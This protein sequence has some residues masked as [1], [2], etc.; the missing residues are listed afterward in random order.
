LRCVLGA[1]FVGLGLA[2]RYGLQFRKLITYMR[3]KYLPKAPAS[4]RAAVVRLE[5]V[6][7]AF[8]RGDSLPSAVV[9]DQ[10]TDLDDAW[11]AV[12]SMFGSPATR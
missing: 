3:H 1:Q 5:L 11:A 10:P 6:V 2:K 4:A 8:E 12:Y 7:E 9:E